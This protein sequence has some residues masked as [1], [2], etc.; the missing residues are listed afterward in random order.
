MS[1]GSAA[2]VIQYGKIALVDPGGKFPTG[3][4]SQP[5]KQTIATAVPA[6]TKRNS[7]SAASAKTTKTVTTIAVRA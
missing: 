5:E 1:E 6:E 3:N 7:S 4:N 2:P